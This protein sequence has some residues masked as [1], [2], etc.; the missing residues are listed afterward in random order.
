MNYTFLYPTRL[1]VAHR[2]R[3]V[4]RINSINH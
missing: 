1:Q 2:F 3:H 4:L